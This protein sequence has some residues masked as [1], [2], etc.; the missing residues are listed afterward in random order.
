MTEQIFWTVLSGVSVFVFGQLIVK[1]AI[2]PI[3]EC[4]KLCGEIAEALIFYANVNVRYSGIQKEGLDEAY[5]AY[6]RLSGRLLARAH[7]IGFYR[8]WAFARLIPRRKDLGNAYRSLIGLSNNVLDNGADASKAKDKYRHD[9]KTIL[10][11]ETGE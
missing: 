11:L 4:R 6:R 8:V 1:F 2:E 10:D 5:N 3:H 9:I 7:V